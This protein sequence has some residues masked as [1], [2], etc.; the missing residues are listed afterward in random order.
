MACRR[1]TMPTEEAAH[2]GQDE[3]PLECAIC[4]ESIE[5][6]TELP[7]R[8][9]VS[10]CMRCWDR[11]LA[12][13]FSDTR[14]A[15]CPT[16]RSEIRV[17][18]D[19][20]SGRLVFSPLLEPEDFRES[21]ERIASQALPVQTRI[22]RQYGRDNPKLVAAVADPRAELLAMRNSEV[23]Q[24]IKALGGSPAGCLEK[25]DLVERV[26]QSAG[27]NDK[28]V[29]YLASLCGAPPRCVCGTPLQRIKITERLRRMLG[30]M[31]APVVALPA[32][33]SIIC[34]ICE[35][36]YDAQRGEEVVW[37][38]EAG[39]QTTLHATA[40]DIC[41]HCFARW[42]GGAPEADPPIDGAASGEQDEAQSD[43]APS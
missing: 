25:S 19:A 27:G 18:F 37:T 26:I 29:S 34:D 1:L 8:C 33:Y 20:A 40:Y 42:V 43:G 36:H 16:C 2:G 13:S 14:K 5:A 17:D 32:G 23:K 38:C 41:G 7:C 35:E 10:Y 31:N 3:G 24:H 30:L 9:N 15:R 28:I 21:M 11:A 22:L 6:S 12:Q 4:M 39:V